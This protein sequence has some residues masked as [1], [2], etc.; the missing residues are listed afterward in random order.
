M[1]LTLGKSAYI[2]LR[3]TSTQK[4]ITLEQV[5]DLLKRYI[6]NTAKTGEQLN[7]NYENFS[8]PYTIEE[9]TEGNINYL[10]LKAADPLYNYLVI[11][12]GKVES[13]EEP[14][15]FIQV[16]LPDEEYRTPGDNAKGNELA[17]YFATT[18]KAELQMFN[19]RV[20][21]YNPRK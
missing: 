6:S 14:E 20:I 13:D 19:E 18:L 3:K 8:F 2:K 4:E 5:K 7:W 15:Y 17:K 12:V 16:V 10:Y 9:K 1:E 21:Y 11:G